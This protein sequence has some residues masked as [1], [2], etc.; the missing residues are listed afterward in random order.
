MIQYFGYTRQ[1]DPIRPPF[2]VDANNN[3][4]FGEQGL[5]SGSTTNTY[6]YD[7]DNDGDGKREGIWL[8]LNYPMQVLLDGRKMVPLFSYTVIDADGLVNLNTAG[9]LSWLPQTNLALQ[10]PFLGQP[11]GLGSGFYPISHSNLGMSSPGEINPFWALVADPENTLYNNWYQAGK[12]GTQPPQYLA[13]SNTAAPLECSYSGREPGSQ[14]Y[15]GFFGLSNTNPASYDMSWIEMA[16]MD[17]LRLLW[18]AP[19][20]NVTIGNSGHESFT[21]DDVLVGRWGD[22]DHLL[23]A[24]G[25]RAPGQ[26]FPPLYDPNTGWPVFPRPGIPLFDDDGDMFAGLTDAGYFYTNKYLGYPNPPTHAGG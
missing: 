15:R 22:V 7:V 25:L 26:L 18:G 9:N 12:I 16:N 17:L 21:I 1:H 8:D 3:G 19:K 5:W 6:E 14:Q 2:K 24:Q 13:L 10:R 11:Q 23:Y 4:I 20:Y